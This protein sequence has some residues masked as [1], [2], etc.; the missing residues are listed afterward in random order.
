MNH[1]FS[2]YIPTAHLFSC[3][4]S[5]HAAVM[6]GRKFAEM[7]YKTTMDPKKTALQ[8]ITPPCT[9]LLAPQEPTDTPG[10]KHPY[11]KRK[12]Y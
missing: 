3:L 1:T 11:K 2:V 9:T 7:I 8:D 4:E 12:K 6:K 5:I 10:S